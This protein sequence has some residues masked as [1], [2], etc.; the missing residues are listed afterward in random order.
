ME[1]PGWM[2][3]FLQP[4]AGPALPSRNRA[5]LSWYRGGGVLFHIG[6]LPLDG[7]VTNLGPFVPRRSQLRAPVFPSLD[8]RHL[9]KLPS[10]NAFLHLPKKTPNHTCKPQYWAPAVCTRCWRKR[11]WAERKRLQWA[12]SARPRGSPSHHRAASPN[13]PPRASLGTR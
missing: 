2:P 3:G 6:D 10:K 13:T 9:R 7:L 4:P 5:W 8:P 11:Q 1:A 12:E